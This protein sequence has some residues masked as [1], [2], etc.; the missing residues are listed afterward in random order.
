[1]FW[2]NIYPEVA[3][4]KSAVY[5]FNKVKM[6]KLMA[7]NMKCQRP[8]SVFFPVA[9]P[10]TGQRILGQSIEQGNRGIPYRLILIKNIVKFTMIRIRIPYIRFLL[11]T[12][13][14]IFFISCN[15]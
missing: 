12:I 11:K 9:R 10:H 7:C 3:E 6:M 15:T 1:M 13:Q 5:G 2:W 4:K 14:V 8:D